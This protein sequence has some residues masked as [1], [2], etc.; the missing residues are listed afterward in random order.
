MQDLFV[1]F[2][3]EI[4]SVGMIAR[5]R[6]RGN[7]TKLFEREIFEKNAEKSGHIRQKQFETIDKI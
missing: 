3:K 7:A 2:S 6:G 1:N 4:S 5:H